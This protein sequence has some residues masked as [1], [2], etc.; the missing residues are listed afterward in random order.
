MKNQNSKKDSDLELKQYIIG[1]F[2]YYL[3]AFSNTMEVLK[4]RRNDSEKKPCFGN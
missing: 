4:R 2:R 1:N 3:N